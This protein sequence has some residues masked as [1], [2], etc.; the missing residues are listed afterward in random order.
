[1]GRT[2]SKVE[3]QLCAGVSVEMSPTQKKLFEYLLARVGEPV[4]IPELLEYMGFDPRNLRVRIIQVRELV[5]NSY[6]LISTR[7]KSY[8]LAPVVVEASK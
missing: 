4:A 3:V 8:T 6:D 5:K 7:G 1:M 2:S